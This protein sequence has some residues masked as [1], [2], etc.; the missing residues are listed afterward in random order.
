MLFKIARIGASPHEFG[1]FGGTRYHGH[2]FS[3]EANISLKPS[4]R[5]LKQNQQRVTLVFNSGVYQFPN[6]QILP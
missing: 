4:S 5:L 1:L 3:K 6:N 2:K